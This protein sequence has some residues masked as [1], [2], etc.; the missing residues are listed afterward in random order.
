MKQSI[1][2]SRIAIYSWRLK[3]WRDGKE[4]ETGTPDAQGHRSMNVDVLESLSKDDPM[5]FVGKGM[6]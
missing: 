1:I 6:R 2:Q 4:Q 3:N 5:P